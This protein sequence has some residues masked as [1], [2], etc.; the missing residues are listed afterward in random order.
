MTP[1]QPQALE[2]QP[3]G[4][5]E[6]SRITGVFFEPSKTFEDVA[7]RPTFWVPLVLVLLFATVYLFLFSQHVGWERML[8]HQFEMSSRTA[9][10]PPEQREAAIQMQLRF[11]PIFG[12]V[13]VLLGVP[14]FD[15]VWAAVLLGIV[16][17]IMSVPVRFKQV[18]AVVCYAA[19]PSLI[20]TMLTIAVMFMKNP[21]D[22]N[23]QNP[24]VFNPGAL[25][26]PA[27][28]SKFLYSFASS[29]DV[30][31]IWTLVLIAFGLKAAGG[32]SITF[33]GALAAVFV[34]WGIW[35]LCKSALAGIF[36]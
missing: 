8:R 24:L 7:A 15:L 21:D 33:G 10:M 32:R 30:F 18:F 3:S 36:S 11:V 27:S 16:K 13:G 12:Y 35:V 28:S 6:I 26:D 20:F 25:M 14:L 29:L 1:E 22:F 17:G 19:M 23:M 34:P 5:S 31:G 4:M 9:Q 2:P